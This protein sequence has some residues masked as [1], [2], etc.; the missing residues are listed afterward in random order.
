[1]DDDNRIERNQA[2]KSAAKHA[3][4]LMA[5]RRPDNG[6]H[7]Y[8][9]LNMVNN[10][11][12]SV[13]AQGYE[14]LA[15]SLLTNGKQYYGTILRFV[16]DGSDIA[17]FDFP[18]PSPYW[19]TL[20]YNGI[21]YPRQV[22]YVNY[23]NMDGNQSVYSFQAFLEMIN[24]ALLLAA[25]D[26]PLVGLAAP[27]MV[28]VPATG[29]C[30][31]IVP[32][33]YV[34]GHPGGAIKIFMSTRLYEFFGNFFSN[35]NGES[36]PAGPGQYANYEIIVKNLNLTNTHDQ[37]PFAPAGTYIMNQE[38]SSLNKW[39]DTTTVRI[40]SAQLGAKQEFISAPNTGDTTMVNSVCCNGN[41]FSSVIAD[42]QPYWGPGDPAG[43]RGYIY[44]V[45]TSQYR[46]FDMIQDELKTIDITIV[47]IDRV[48]N[49]KPLFI[50]PHQSIQIKFL[51]SK[52]SATF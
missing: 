3:E 47:L 52:K 29:L 30:P 35:Y 13:P 16:I 46:Y 26:V 44:Y 34:T 41:L 1:M 22:M 25:G 27:Y 37:T 51:F 15:Q 31:I 36:L 49:Q 12:V 19:V 50:P 10:Q 33:D 28:Y 48:G 23:N 42:F 4:Q 18:D 7:I 6:D 14:Q 45:P 43:P 20:S 40:L 32:Q 8:Y 11:D 2:V 21:Y 17:I 24:N 5:N 9:N 39:F 38:Y